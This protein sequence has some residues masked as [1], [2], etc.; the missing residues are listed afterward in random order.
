MALV[1]AYKGGVNYPDVFGTTGIWDSIIYRYLSER[2]IAIPPN[3]AKH[4]KS[5]SWWLREKTPRVGMSEW[6]TSFDLN[7]L[8]PNLIVQYNMSPETLIRTP[9]DM[10]PMG[11]DT[12]LADDSP[13]K[14]ILKFLMALRLPLMALRIAKTSVALCLRSLL[15]CMMRGR[16]TKNKMLELQQKSQSDGSHDLKREINRLNNT[17]S[18]RSRFCSTRF[19]AHSAINTSV[20]SKCPLLKALHY[21]VNYLF[22]WAEKAHEQIHEQTTQDR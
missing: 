18:K 10:Y 17:H 6:I 14:L 16:E 12:Y 21:L 15:V 7:S 11:V 20:T 5:I 2:K 9:A 19:M 13:R 4:K 8:Y 3:N 22:R 1:I